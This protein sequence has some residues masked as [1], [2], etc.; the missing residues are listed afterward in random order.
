M[1]PAPDGRFHQ[2][3]SAR[4]SAF[5]V[6]WWVLVGRHRHAST[7]S[8][9]LLYHLNHGSFAACVSAAHAGEPSLSIVEQLAARFPP[10]YPRFQ[11][12]LDLVAEV[13]QAIEGRQGPERYR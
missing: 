11:T 12:A 8:Y 13:G 1:E 6:E 2:T 7:A 10:V 3:C 4:H 5:V 9:S